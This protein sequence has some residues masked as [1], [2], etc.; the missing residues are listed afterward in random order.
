MNEDHMFKE[1]S[2]CEP[3][4]CE[5]AIMP[6]TNHT[7]LSHPQRDRGRL[8]GHS[9][10]ARRSP[11]PGWNSSADPL[12]SRPLLSA[13]EERALAERIKRG[14]A[15][16]RKQLIL[17]NLRL[18]VSIARKYRSSSLSFDDLVQ[19]GNLGLIRASQDFDPSVRDARFSTYAKLWIRAFIHRALIANDSLIRIPEYIFLLRKRYYRVIDALGGLEC[20]AACDRERLS[21]DQVAMETGISPRQLKPSK[22]ALIGREARSERDEDGA[23]ISITE[24]I[25]DHRRPDDEAA[26]QEERLRLEAA[27]QQLNPFEAWV[28]RER[29]GLSISIAGED[30]WSTPVPLAVR[31]TDDD[32]TSSS[33]ANPPGRCRSYFHRTYPELA[34][35]CGL[36]SHRIHQ[37]ERTALK[38]LRDVL[39]RRLFQAV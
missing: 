15:I 1:P 2:I 25:V 23:T 33:H 21:I 24:V 39:G 28:L 7:R 17:A 31:S 35:G 6:G 36:S 37:V 4:S 9:R 5:R 30:D 8:R 22:L 18:V 11:Q 10:L 32:R 20:M 12:R 27:L 3:S 29:Y 19:E 14:D 26:N 38:K 13:I 16:A 34:Q